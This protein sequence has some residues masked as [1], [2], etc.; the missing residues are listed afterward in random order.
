MDESKERVGGNFLLTEIQS[1]TTVCKLKK[2]LLAKLR[3]RALGNLNGP[4]GLSVDQVF[5][6]FKGEVLK[7]TA[8]VSSVVQ[9]G[10]RILFQMCEPGLGGMRPKKHTM[11]THNRHHHHQYTHPGSTSSSSA[12]VSSSSNASCSSSS[13]KAV[14]QPHINEVLSQSPN[15]EVLSQC[16]LHMRVGDSM[17][18]GDWGFGEQQMTLLS[19]DATA[20]ACARVS[21]EVGSFAPLE[22]TAVGNCMSSACSDSS[23]IYQILHSDDAVMTGFMCGTDVVPPED[24]CPGRVSLRVYA[25]VAWV[26]MGTEGMRLSPAMQGIEQ[27]CWVLA[28]G[29]ISDHNENVL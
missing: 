18:V 20:S 28:L 9:D 5:L 3:D 6:R 10:E 19:N 21:S 16:L 24:I 1:A 13:G 11:H 15:D 29:L 14:C 22:L 4:A 26:L 12:S 23:V 2:I 17:S 27:L 7:D 8:I 25:V